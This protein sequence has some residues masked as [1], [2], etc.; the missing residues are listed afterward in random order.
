[1]T[2][3]VVPAVAVDG[4]RVDYQ[5]SWNPF[6]AGSLTVEAD[7]V[8]TGNVRLVLDGTVRAQGSS[9]PI[10]ADDAA[11]QELLPGD[12]RAVSIPLRSV[13]PLIVASAE[14]QVAPTVVTPDGGEAVDLEPVTAT[15]TAAAVPWSQLLVVLGTALVLSALLAGRSRSRSRVAALVRQAKEE[16]RREGARPG[17]AEGV[18]ANADDR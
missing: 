6:A 12:R 1:M 4:M 16:G 15:A 8:N 13:W 18:T 9:A 17:R 5:M 10:V 3:D 2:G 14:L 11:R 7:I